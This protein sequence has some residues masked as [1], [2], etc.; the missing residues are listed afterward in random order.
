MYLTEITAGITE[1]QLQEAINAQLRLVELNALEGTWKCTATLT[2]KDPARAI[3]WLDCTSQTKQNV[4]V[5]AGLL[6]GM[7]L[8]GQVN[9]FTSSYF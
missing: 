8:W 3:A 4:A 1:D 7:S 5:V 9:L 6:N 2:L